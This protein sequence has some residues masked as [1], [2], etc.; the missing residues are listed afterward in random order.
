M[1]RNIWLAVLL[2]L[3]LSGCGGG[4]KLFVVKDA[5]LVASNDQDFDLLVRPHE[6]LGIKLTPAIMAG[7]VTVLKGFTISKKIF[8]GEEYPGRRR[9]NGWFVAP[10]GLEYFVQIVRVQVNRKGVYEY[11]A[12]VDG[13]P[14]ELRGG[15]IYGLSS[16]LDFVMNFEGKDTKIVGTDFPKIRGYRGSIAALFGTPVD[17]L[18]LDKRNKFGKFEF[19]EQIKKLN[20]YTL[21]NEGYELA[22]EYTE[23]DFR[24]I[25]ILN[26]GYGMWEKFALHGTAELSV[27][28]IPEP[29][30]VAIGAGTSVGLAMI[31]F[32]VSQGG[33]S[34][35]WDYMSG[36]QTNDVVSFKEMWFDKLREEHL[37]MLNNEI[38]TLEEKL[39]GKKPQPAKFVKKVAVAN[40]RR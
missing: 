9:W 27:P 14:E 2:S 38:N 39:N 6:S 18:K 30:T 17:D 13:L 35:G 40:E 4:A 34:N 20:R 16:K 5:P 10:S 32:Y 37:L 33:I 11:K 1:K 25:N 8:Y 15:R 24:K 29:M 36:P 3:I 22:C 26:P 19:I 28:L 31:D 23:N 12:I 21:K 7:R